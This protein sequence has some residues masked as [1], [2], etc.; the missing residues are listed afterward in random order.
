MIK[1]IFLD[2]DGTLVSFHTHCISPA[3]LSALHHLQAQG[4]KLFVSTGRHPQ[5]LSY[6]RSAFPFDGWVTLSGQYCFCGNQVVHRNPMDHQAVAELVEATRSDAFSCIYLEES[7]LYINFA[8]THTKAFLTDLDLPLPPI[9]DPRRALD[10]HLYQAIAFLPKE[11][12]HL[13]LDKAPHLKTTRWHPH[14]L[15]VI[16]ASGGKDK[17]MDAILN[18]FHIPLEDS[19]A[20]GDGENDLSMLLHAGIGVAMGSASD[21]VKGQADYVTGTVDEDGILTALKHFSLL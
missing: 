10:A 5:M 18:H 19:M 1:A 17:G 8:D 11:K 21:Y 6:V 2:V 15:D 16:P 9:Q 20:F 3:V 12:E 7:Q 14:F 4:I 13:L